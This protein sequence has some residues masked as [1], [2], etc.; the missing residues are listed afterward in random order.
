MARKILDE[1]ATRIVAEVLQPILVDLIDLTLQAKHVHWTL[2]GPRFLPLHRQL[3]EIVAAAR[4]WA[5]DVA[6]RL[7]ALDVAPDGRV[8]VVAKESTLGTIEAGFMADAQAVS[9]ISDR[10][11]AVSAHVRR[12]IAATER[13][14]AV[15]QDLL[16]SIAGEAEHHLW[17]LQSH[18]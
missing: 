6:E 18:E 9:R 17:L 12:S 14:D 16:I 1:S 13:A 15:T 10:L 2:R 8:S 3:D 7:A 4:K 11:T 5:D